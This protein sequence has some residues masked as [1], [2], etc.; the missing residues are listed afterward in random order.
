[1]LVRTRKNRNLVILRVRMNSAAPL[2][3]PVWQFLPRLSIWIPEVSAI[4]LLLIHPR[5]METHITE[6]HIN[7]CSQQHYSLLTV[8]QQKQS[9]CLLTDE[10]INKIC[11]MH[12]MEYYPTNRNEALLH[13]TRFMNLENIMLS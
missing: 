13:A 8:K 10:W 5:K 12:T 11:Y 7:E 6:K 4:P 3:K 9:K 1:M 2:W